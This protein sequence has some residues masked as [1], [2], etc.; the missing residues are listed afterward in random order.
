VGRAPTI[1]KGLDAFGDHDADSVL[2]AGIFEHLDRCMALAAQALAEGSAPFGSVLVSADGQVLR[3]ARNRTVGGDP[4]RHPEMEL[5]R[6]AIRYLRP[7][8]RSTATVYTSGEHCPMCAAAHALAGLGRIVYAASCEQLDE[9]MREGGRGR[10]RMTL[11]PV[12]SIIP[13]AAVCGPFL[14]YAEPLRLMV[15]QYQRSRSSPTHVTTPR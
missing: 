12:G 9:W 5:V 2:S 6:F 7:D 3:E 13:D 14:R 8:Q 4:T 1:P 10:G 15:I 11:M